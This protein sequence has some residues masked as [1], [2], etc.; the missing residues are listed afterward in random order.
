MEWKSLLLL[1]QKDFAERFLVHFFKME[2]SLTCL[3]LG[4]FDAFSSGQGTSDLAG[5]KMKSNSFLPQKL[6]QFWM[7]IAIFYRNFEHLK[8]EKN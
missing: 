3:S 8:T 2:S 7:V 4:D 6:S 1:P 5:V